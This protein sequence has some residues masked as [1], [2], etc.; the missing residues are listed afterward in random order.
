MKKKRSLFVIILLII[1][2]ISCY[3]IDVAIQKKLTRKDAETAGIELFY[4]QVELTTNQVDSFIDGKVSRDAVQ[5]GVDYL[6]NAY[7]QYTVLTYSLDL[8]DSRHYQDVKYSFWH[9]YWNTVTNTDLS[10]DDLMKLESLE[11]NLKE[12][13]NEVSSEEAKLK[14]EIAKY[15]VR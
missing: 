7:D 14:E 3:V 4:K 2:I 12:I 10:G 9:Q 5:S 8:E 15:W 1:T 13:L 6:L 11:K